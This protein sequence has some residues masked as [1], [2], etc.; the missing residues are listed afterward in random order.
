MNKRIRAALPL[1]S[2]ARISPTGKDTAWKLEILAF[3]NRG[4]D[5]CPG[6][7]PKLPQ[8]FLFSVN[9][10]RYVIRARQ[11]FG[12]SIDVGIIGSDRFSVLLNELGA[13]R[14][15]SAKGKCKAN[16]EDRLQTEFLMTKRHRK[17]YF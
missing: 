12:K 11:R 9:V 16:E 14:I 2:A 1:H 7:G 4:F 17:Q 10:K 8:L 15:G 6:F 3:C 5:V 13:G